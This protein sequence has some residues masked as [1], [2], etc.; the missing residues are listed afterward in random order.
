MGRFGVNRAFTECEACGHPRMAHFGGG[1]HCGCTGA[2]VISEFGRPE[3]ATDLVD[4]L[5]AQIQVAKNEQSECWQLIND[6]AALRRDGRAEEAV[7]TARRAK[8]CAASPS[9]EVS[10]VTVLVAGLC[11]LWKDEEARQEGEAALRIEASPFLLRALGRAWFLGYAAT[12]VID[13]KTRADECFGL[14]DEHDA[15]LA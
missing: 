4:A 14:A 12:G 15:V 11:D 5:S 6:A 8:E 7:S 10:A 1:C 9:D 3:R 2:S 13:F